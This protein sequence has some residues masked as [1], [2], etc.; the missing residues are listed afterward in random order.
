MIMS[1]M[2]LLSAIF[3]FASTFTLFDSE[4]VVVLLS[5]FVIEL[6]VELFLIPLSPVPCVIA[7]YLSLFSSKSR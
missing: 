2:K 5:E 1:S 7:S 6:S 4:I 3:E